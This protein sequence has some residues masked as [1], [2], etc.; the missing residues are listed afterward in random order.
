MLYTAFVHKVP[1]LLISRP[2]QCREILG[3][4]ILNICMD[5]LWLACGCGVDYFDR[6]HVTL[7]N[8]VNFVFLTDSA[9]EY[10]VA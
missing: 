8:K 3:N 4:G 6:V 7:V 5:I 1:R 10:T 9:S 2:R